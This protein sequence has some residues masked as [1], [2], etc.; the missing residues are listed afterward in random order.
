[1]NK[2]SIK[3]KVKV[4]LEIEVPDAWG[5]DCALSQVYSQAKEKAL[6]ILLQTRIPG[7]RIL[8]P[9]VVTAICYEQDVSS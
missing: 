6:S 8:M 3:A 1:M 4:T 9:T 2:V 5:T 7:V